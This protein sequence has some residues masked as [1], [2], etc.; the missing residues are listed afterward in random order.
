MFK[1]YIF[2]GVL[3]I[4]YVILIITGFSIVGTPY[5]QQLKSQDQLRSQRIRQLSSA[6]QNY[7]YKNKKLPTSIAELSSSGQDMRDISTD[8]VSK[9]PFVYTVNSPTQYEIC[10]DFSTEI[11]VD[12]DI[13]GYGGG[14]PGNDN[15]AIHKKGNVCMKTTIP[16]DELS[17]PQMSAPQNESQKIDPKVD[18]NSK[19]GIDY[20]LKQTT[21]T[22]DPLAP[23][24][25]QGWGILKWGNF[26]F[27]INETGSQMYEIKNNPDE[28]FLAL[29]TLF[30]NSDPD[31]K[32]TGNGESK[33]SYSLDPLSLTN[34]KG[35]ISRMNMEGTSDYIDVTTM[36]GSIERTGTFPNVRTSGALGFFVKKS[37]F[38]NPDKTASYALRYDDGSADK[39][40]LNVKV[41]IL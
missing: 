28:Y 12:E 30:Q 24:P 1:Y 20:L 39:H 18:F 37:D 25:N 13:Y 10:A 11:T 6:I 16:S 9:V 32:T 4:I 40:V 41:K 7:I 31:C 33:C 17:A 29:S 34:L 22:F 23:E 21:V 3:T 19:V 15:P 5:E 36:W 38:S 14:R 8:P 27:S 2:I 26:S 35:D